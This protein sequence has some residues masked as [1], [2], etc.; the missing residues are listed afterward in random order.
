[1]SDIDDDPANV[2]YWE[3]AKVFVEQFPQMAEGY[4]EVAG[5]TTEEFNQS[6]PSELCDKYKRTSNRLRQH[7]L[8][9]A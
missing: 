1:M 7:M 8:G 5:I 3:L 2:E 6:T 9:M 4:A